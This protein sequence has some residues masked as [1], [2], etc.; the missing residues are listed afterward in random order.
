MTDTVTDTFS[1]GFS[2]AD[3]AAN[4]GDG[5]FTTMQLEAGSV[6]LLAQH[7]SRL[8]HDAGKLG[9]N[10]SAQSLHHAISNAARQY[11]HGVL[12]CVVSA[13]EG[14]RGYARATQVQPSLHV[15]HHSLP[16]HYAH[17][18]QQGM[19]LSVAQ[20]RLAVQ[21][22]LA[23]LKHLNRLE[24]VLIKQELVGSEA[25]DALVCDYQGRLIEASAANVFWS[26]QGRWFTPSLNGCGV[27]G[28]MRGF[29]MEWMRIRGMNVEV[30]DFTPADC[31]RAD[32]VMLTNALMGLMP[33]KRLMLEG[34][35]YTFSINTIIELRQSMDSHYRESYA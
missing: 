2:I 27:S 29:V 17:M 33:V 4:Y 19:S 7:V 21:P 10:V 32:S 6:A 23:G 20:T 31:A 15:S 14:G 9:I 5:V 16:G 24:Q 28:V 8:K 34:A 11:Q 30:G 26:H 13:G 22:V 18:R 1:H 25:D 12:K 3:R 35:S